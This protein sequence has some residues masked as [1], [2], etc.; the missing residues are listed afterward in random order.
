VDEDD[1]TGVMREN[2]EDVDELDPST[3]NIDANIGRPVP[4]SIASV[5]VVPTPDRVAL[6]VGLVVRPVY[7]PAPMAESEVL[8][9]L[10][11]EKSIIGVGNTA[12]K[13]K[14]RTTVVVKSDADLS[15]DMDI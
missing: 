1:E 10:L 13:L 12:N 7:D 4:E 15:A 11:G 8:M 3:P 14:T 6:S 5:T 9:K 2:F